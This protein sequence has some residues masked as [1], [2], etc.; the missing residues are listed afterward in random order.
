MT[1]P[2]DM[3]RVYIN[4]DHIR[5]KTW[6]DWFRVTTIVAVGIAMLALIAIIA[7]TL[8]IVAAVV[9][10][11]AGAYLY[12]ANLFRRRRSGREVGP[13]QGNYDA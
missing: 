1:D 3:P 9:A 6:R 5:P 8:L 7:S 2:R 11:V 12:I 13:Y 4:W 10:L